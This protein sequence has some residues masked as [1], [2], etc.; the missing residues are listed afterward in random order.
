GVVAQGTLLRELLGD[1]LKDGGNA[2]VAE[3]LG[4]AVTHVAGVDGPVSHR[5]H[6]TAPEKF[7]VT[8]D[9]PAEVLEALVPDAAGVPGG[10]A[11][12]REW[13]GGDLRGRKGGQE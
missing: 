1:V 12:L 3:V 7:G 10:R 13:N 2:L 4:G 9:R 6:G 8:L 5:E 11:K